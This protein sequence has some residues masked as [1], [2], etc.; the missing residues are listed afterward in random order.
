MLKRVDE[1]VYR[2][3]KEMID[4]KFPAGVITT[5]GLKENAVGLPETSTKNVTKE[6]LDKVEEYKAKIISGEI[7]V[8]TAQ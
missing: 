8:P 4:G 6:I 2:V 1:A 3:S 7:T 5:L